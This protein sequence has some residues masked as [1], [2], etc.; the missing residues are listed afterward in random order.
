MEANASLGGGV[1]MT[2]GST[3]RDPAAEVAGSTG[4][5]VALAGALAAL[6][7]E[8][9]VARDSSG[10]SQFHVEEVVVEF[11]VQVTPD[12]QGHLKFWVVN[13]GGAAALPANHRVRVRLIPSVGGYD[14]AGEPGG[15]GDYA[16]APG[17]DW[18]RDAARSWD[19]GDRPR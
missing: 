5:P 16:E 2:D 15:G 17:E 12:T 10:L 3:E 6:G 11:S 19:E 4:D 13:T 1:T 9:A 14:Y 18:D 8:V 7:E